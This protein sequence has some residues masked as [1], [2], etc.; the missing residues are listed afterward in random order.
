MDSNRTPLLQIVLFTSLLTVGL[1]VGQ[2]LL[3]EPDESA[4]DSLDNAEGV[5]SAQ[6]PENAESPAEEAR[7]EAAAAAPAEELS[8]E[9][10]R[11]RWEN[12][13]RF[14][15]STSLVEAEVSNLNT[16]LL[17]LVMKNPRYDRDG[18]PHQ[19]VT[20]NEEAFL[21]LGVSLPGIPMPADAVWQGEQVSPTKVVFSWSGSG[22]RVRR[23]LEVIDD[24]AHAYQIWATTQ[25]TNIDQPSRDYRLTTSAY[26]YVSL[27]DEGSD[28]LLAFAS[29]SPAISEN[30]CAYGE[31]FEREMRE[32]DED[33][34][35]E[36]SYGPGVKLTGVGDAFFAIA[37]TPDQGT[38]DSCRLTRSKRGTVT[39]VVGTL[40][41]AELIY[42]SHTLATGESNL[43]RTLVYAGPKAMDAIQ[44]A[45]HGLSLLVD[46]G[47]FDPVAGV[48]VD[49]LKVL[50]DFTGNWGF[51]IILLTLIVRLML[52][53]LTAKS[54]KSMGKMRLLKP[55]MD[56]INELYADDREAKGAAIM[57]LYRREKVSPLG[58]CLPMLAQM[59]IFFALYQSLMTNV[60]L[61]NAPF[62]GW[63]TDLSSSDPF[64][65]LP[66][67]LGVLMFFQQRLAPAGGMDPTQ[68]KIMMWAMPIFLTGIML[69]LPAG[70]CLYMVTSSAL[71]IAQQTWIH[72]QLDK[73]AAENQDPNATKESGSSNPQPTPTKSK[74]KPTGL[75]D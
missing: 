44:S 53:P 55:E 33:P 75:L 18:E 21:P 42:A 24:P 67:S 64:Y 62:V 4:L 56:R 28:G 51:A 1:M 32:D 63:L 59:P 49:L 27:D 36:T 61:Y 29:R 26:H 3:G 25:V 17:S 11:S 74:K 58:G 2:E 34:D 72:R 6:T 52:F 15:L 19:M 47:W 40:F 70:L 23:A 54:M 14:T 7:V 22:F 37:F 16:G 73:I 38:A 57:E 41:G 39:A 13:Q 71:G 20:T 48:M 68:R 31:E 65:I 45:G 60:E 12:Q 9:D 35:V 46:L 10:R 50:S 8:A 66:V 69:V 30:L 5:A 43:H